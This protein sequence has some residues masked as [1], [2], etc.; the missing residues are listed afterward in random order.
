MGINVTH[1]EAD[2]QRE[3]QRILQ[4]RR[5][6]DITT[7]SGTHTDLH[8]R[9]NQPDPNFR[10]KFVNKRARAVAKAQTL[11][12][13]IVPTSDSTQADY[14]VHKDGAQ[15]LGEGSDVVLMREP[16]EL[17]EMKRAEDEERQRQV[18]QAVNDTARDN[19]NRIARNEL[20]T[21]AHRDITEDRSV[22]G[23]ARTIRDGRP[24][25]SAE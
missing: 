19:I 7:L 20:R 13:E 23:G 4:R 14:G 12:F 17:Y 16:V 3:Y 25:K 24:R 21:P 18:I 6:H 10:Y 1:D 11:G 9:S 5:K 15:Q 22:D 2:K 8:G